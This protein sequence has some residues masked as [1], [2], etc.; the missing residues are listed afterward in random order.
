MAFVVDT[1]LR[2]PSAYKVSSSYAFPFGRHDAL[3]VSA[4]VDLV[5]L[6]FDLE[7]G[8]PWRGQ[9]FYQFRC[10]IRHFILDYFGK[11]LSDGPRDLATLT[12]DL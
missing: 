2:I 7:T 3:L 4:L 10:F 12:F 6:T 9:S 1:G 11:Q 5:T 8:I